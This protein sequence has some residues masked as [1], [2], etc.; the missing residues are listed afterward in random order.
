LNL[1]ILHT[2]SSSGWGGQ[3]I[4]IL[5]EAEGMRARGHDV[6]LA[7]TKGGALIAKARERG[8]C[9]YEMKFSKLGCLHS[10]WML[11]KIILRH[12][13]QIVNTHSSLDSWL[14]GMAARLL[15]RKIV[16]TR[17]LSTKIRPGLNSFLLYRTLA[18]SVVT[19]SSCILPMICKQAKLPL[20]R[21]QCVPT[22]V[23]P[24][25]FR[26]FPE[27]VKEFKKKLLKPGQQFLVGTV[28]VVRSWKGILDLMQAAKIVKETNDSVHWV[29]VGGG[30]VHHFEDKIE[31]LGIQ[32]VFTFVGHLDDPCHAISALDVFL[33]LSTAN[34]G[35]SQASLQAAFLERPLV[36]TSVGG[37]PE[38]CINEVTGKVVP[39]FSPQE[40]ASVVL[41]LLEN[42]SQREKMGKSAKQLVE[43]KFLLSATLDKMEKVYQSVL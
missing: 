24:S 36:T 10:L 5:R 23:D 32:D 41:N 12:R 27:E 19:T 25:L 20:S 9:V 30:Y 22:G 43:K 15:G 40:V 37:L 4:R 11:C 28:C 18:D 17:H 33:L 13:I 21:V 3:E 38:V 16:R 26:V 35:I 6:I 42:P 34:E 29:V 8:F 2:E 1:R 39:P 7:V 31:K 14:G